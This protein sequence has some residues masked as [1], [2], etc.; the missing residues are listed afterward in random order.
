MADL[1]NFERISECYHTLATEVGLIGNLS[2]INNEAMAQRRHD[3]VVNMLNA[4][5]TS[6]AAINTR[7]AAR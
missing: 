1:P 6:I 7:I 2:V 4:I 5:N 3:E